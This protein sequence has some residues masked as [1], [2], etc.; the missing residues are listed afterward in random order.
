MRTVQHF[1]RTGITRTML[2]VV[3]CLAARL[4]SAETVNAIWNS[5]TDVPVTANGYTST[6]NTVNFTLNFAPDTGTDLV[7]VRNTALD[8]IVGTFDNL[9]NGQPVALSFGGTIYRF[10]A[11][12]YG[13]SGNDLVL[14]WASS[15]AFAWGKNTSGQL[16]DSTTTNRLL[17]VPVTTT[18]VLAGKTVVG[19]APAYRH[20]LAVFS[21]GTV[22]AWGTNSYGQLGDN[23][24]IAHLEPV[25]VNMGSGVSALYGKTVVAIAA[26]DSHSL[27]LC[28]DGTVAAWG[29]NANGQLGNN[30]T[31]SSFVPVAVNADSG[32]SA[33]YGKTAVAIA[34]G[35]GHS[36]ALCSD[37]TVAA[38]GN[39]MWGQLGDNT[40]TNRSVPAS[41]N[42][43]S[44]SALYAK[45]VVAIA[46]G[47]SHS[48]A[49]CSDGTLAAWGKNGQGQLGDN[50]SGINRLVPVSV[51]KDS[52]SA[53]Y[54]KTVVAIAAGG[55]HSLALCSV[56]TV[57]AWGWNVNGE[58]GDSSTMTQRNVPVAVNT[59]SG[60]S[61]LYGKTVLTV[62]ACE[63][64]N[65]TLCSDGTVAAWGDDESGQL[66]DNTT[67]ARRPVPV[68]VNITRLAI[69]Q[70]L[71]RVFNGPTC[72]HSLALVAAPPVSEIT[73]T[74]PQTLTNGSFQFTFT[75]T[76]GAFFGVLAATNPALPLSNWT[77]IT[78]LTE[79]SSGQFQFTD[80]QAAN[81]L[82][83]FYRVHSP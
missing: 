79:V 16:G 68:A 52:G 38:W 49:L 44:G 5:A 36:L 75:N 13:G 80:P 74:D 55:D 19:L 41:V 25:A 43:A 64:H 47:G 71:A 46:A 51:N 69:G 57:A 61:A 48:L 11:N 81:T 37:G 27:A 54:G 20:S 58:L 23:T 10:V 18:G 62:V 34:A 60:A 78:G 14:V 29:Y 31:N 30:T 26:G 9:I 70:R 2:L 72:Y 32:V 66:G 7:V 67:A 6:G 39:N 53:L 1:I 45:T 76:P 33:L 73:L 17:P 22:A 63:L 21:D 50:T 65:L 12:Y 15:R 59:N 28:S 24:T 56:G 4:A 82:Q 77:S 3:F 8:F 40:T 83:R 35:H 42:T